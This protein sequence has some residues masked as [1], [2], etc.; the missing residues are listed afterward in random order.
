[1]S[2]FN[3]KSLIFYGTAICSVVTLFAIVTAYG[4]AN[5]K[6]SRPIDGDYSFQLP[7]MR[8][9]STGNQVNLSIQQSG[10]YVAAALTDAQ[11]IK[12]NDKKSSKAMTLNGHWKNQQLILEGVVPSKILC[13]TSQQQSRNSMV[14]SKIQGSF[15]QSAFTG[16]LLLGSVNNIQLNPIQ[17]NAQKQT[18]S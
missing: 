18:Q 12:A 7:P 14:N 2:H 8:G 16:T 13:A 4:E 1:M 10:I 15:R 9:C 5:L 11:A 3:V 6:A 17:I